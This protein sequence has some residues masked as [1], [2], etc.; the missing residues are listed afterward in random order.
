ME[1]TDLKGSCCVERVTVIESGNVWIIKRRPEFKPLPD[2]QRPD[3]GYDDILITPGQNPL[4]PSHIVPVEI[5]IPKKYKDLQGILKET[6]PH[7]RNNE[8]DCEVCGEA[9][10]FL[11]GLKKRTES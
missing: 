4:D 10:K 3:S 8:N 6:I 1:C 2:F 11:I 5:I 9:L 7:L